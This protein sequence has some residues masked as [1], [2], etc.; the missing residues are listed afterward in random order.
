MLTARSRREVAIDLG[1]SNTLVW[2]RGEGLLAAEPSAVAIDRATGETIAAG[3]EAR[4]MLGRAPTRIRVIEPLR[5]GVIDDFEATTLLLRH[6]LR[7]ALPRRRGI[8]DALVCV[9]LDV[10]AVERRAVEEA[11][12]D[13]GV[14]SV[15][16]M[17]EPL[18]AA[19]G[20]GLPLAEPSGSVVVD[21]GGGTTEIAV[22][23]LGGIVSSAS[24][25]VGGRHLDEAIQGHLRRRHDLLIGL[26]AAEELKLAVART[27]PEPGLHAEVRG[28]A[29]RSGL[30]RGVVVT[31]EEIAGAIDE[32][33]NR[34]LTAIR[35]SLSC[36]P[37]DLAAD[38]MD[39]CLLLTGGGALLTGLAER[40]RA[41]LGVPLHIAD[42][43]FHAVARGAG[44]AL[45]EM[46]VIRRTSAATR[47][48]S[49]AVDAGRRPLRFR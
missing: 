10:T 24:V 35:E 43:S 14:R 38:L 7:T 4:S 47:R 44:M 34:I 30:P 6:A 46:R 29:I 1:T 27:P 33:L 31:G 15:H 22:V 9:P 5:D 16:V 25:R 21:I 48:R 40:I 41:E 12:R 18:A 26:A 20:G 49:R 3:R 13:A 32:P 17:E 36:T 37:P 23:S 42:G 39:T 8:R 45:E 2:V 28:R 19:I 11:V